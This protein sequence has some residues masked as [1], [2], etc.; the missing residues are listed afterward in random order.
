[1]VFS[2]AGGQLIRAANQDWE[3][4]VLT[5][6]DDWVYLPTWL[7]MNPPAFF[8]ADKSS[9]QGMNSMPPPVTVAQALGAEDA[10]SIDWNGCEIGV[11]F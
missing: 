5:H 1:M 3:I 7:S 11:E 8:A 6:L 10:K 9:F 4:G 2:L